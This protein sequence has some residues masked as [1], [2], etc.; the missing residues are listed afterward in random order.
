M[1]DIS[2]FM[3]KAFLLLT[4]GMIPTSIVAPVSAFMSLRICACSLENTG[5]VRK[6]S[7]PA[8][9]FLFILS[10]S[11]FVLSLFWLIAPP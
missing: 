5:C 4:S 6:N 9:I 1:P 3:N 7:A 10:I 2:F 11:N 8:S